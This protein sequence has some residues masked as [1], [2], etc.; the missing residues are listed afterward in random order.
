MEQN[1]EIAVFSRKGVGK[2]KL[3]STLTIDLDERTITLNLYEKA[4][5]DKA[6]GNNYTW[7]K[8][9]DAI[10]RKRGRRTGV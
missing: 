9:K 7:L 1:V 2:E 6:L 4:L 8:R 10:E 5:L 3:F